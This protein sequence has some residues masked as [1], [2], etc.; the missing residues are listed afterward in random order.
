M[1]H[2]APFKH[3]V[4]SFPSNLFA[5]VILIRYI[6]SG[7]GQ[8][9]QPMRETLSR[10]GLPV[11]LF[12]FNYSGVRAVDAQ[13]FARCDGT[14]PRSDD[15]QLGLHG[16]LHTGILTSPAPP[17]KDRQSH[18]S[19]LL[20]HTSPPRARILVGIRVFFVGGAKKSSLWI[21][22][23]TDQHVEWKSP[24]TDRPSAWRSL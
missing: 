9:S 6:G 1:R 16:P 5:Y 22:H 15:K 11:F 21:R 24:P 18:F 14:F 20:G 17:S 4:A 13:K 2:V 3:E 12:L 23:R 10:M 7:C 19:L 8:R